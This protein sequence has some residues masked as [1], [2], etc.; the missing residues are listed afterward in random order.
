MHAHRLWAGWPSSHTAGTS[1]RRA[2]RLSFL[3][4][5]T[6]G[7]AAGL[8]VTPYRWT[9]RTCL[10]SLQRR[11]KECPGPVLSFF[12]GCTSSGGIAG[13]KRGVC[14][15]PLTPAPKHGVCP[16]GTQVTWHQ[17]P[18]TSSFAS[19]EPFSPRVPAAVS[20]AKWTPCSTATPGAREFGTNLWRPTASGHRLV[21]FCPSACSVV[22]MDH[23]GRPRGQCQADHRPQNPTQWPTPL[24]ETQSGRPWPNS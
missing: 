14:P 5:S 9:F 6:G 20:L 12:R 13:P 23:Q 10:N 16:G 21:T 8:P 11:C 24:L 4:H 1:A 3:P 2:S 7:Y 15:E 22:A 19:T 17:Q 18:R